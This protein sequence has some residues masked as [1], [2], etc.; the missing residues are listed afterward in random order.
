M[1]E[2]AGCRVV[3]LGADGTA[4]DSSAVNV[5]SCRIETNPPGAADAGVPC[6]I[7][8]RGAQRFELTL[9]F[10]DTRPLS[11]GRRCLRFLLGLRWWQPFPRGY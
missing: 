1:V 9:T 4:L 3:R 10:T 11:R 6:P 5:E 8:V 7:V 2:I